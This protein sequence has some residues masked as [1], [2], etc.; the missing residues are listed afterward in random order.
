MRLR[1]IGVTF[2]ALLALPLACKKDEQPPPQPPPYQPYPAQPAPAA[3]PPAQPTAA[4]PAPAQPVPAQP[5]QPAPAAPAPAGAMSQPS[6]MA[7]ACSNDAACLTHRCNT[8]FG[9]CAWPC[10]SDNDCVTG[11]HCMAGACVPKMQ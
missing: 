4:Q 2:G 6:P 5:G 9:K 3:P 7:L 1:L 8:Q 10:Q 11:N